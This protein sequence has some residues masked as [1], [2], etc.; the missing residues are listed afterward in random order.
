MAQMNKLITFL[1]TLISVIGVGVAF[2]NGGG[3]N[4]IKIRYADERGHTE[5]N[6]LDSRH[7]FSFGSYDAPAHMGF[8]SLRVINE[9]IIE[10]G[11]G[12]GTHPHKD[13]EIITYVLEGE[14]EHKDSL[15]NGSVIKPGEVQRMS[16]GSGVTHSEFN[17]SRENPVHL[18]QIWFLPSKEGVEPGYE[19]KPFLRKD[20]LR[21]LKLVASRTG[22]EGSVSLNQDVDMYVGVL[23]NEKD[24]FSYS[25][26]S[27]RKVWVQIARGTVSMNGFVLKAGDG[28]AIEKAKLLKF[29]KA[30]N[31]EIIIFDMGL[32]S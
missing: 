5:L 7:T 23:E 28:A 31:A 22:R 8:G 29:N 14:L 24:I 2:G 10:P 13:M 25:V 11:K 20:K 3:N 18:L 30:K 26:L 16:A 4:M 9:D 32:K 17:H 21:K 15:G 12:F 6:W 27:K 1:I 19:Q